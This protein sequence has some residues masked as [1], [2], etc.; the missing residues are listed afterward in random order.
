[1][2]LDH[3]GQSHIAIVANMYICLNGNTHDTINDRT[4]LLMYNSLRDVKS[5]M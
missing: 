1:M 2:K 3:G 5:P 4:S